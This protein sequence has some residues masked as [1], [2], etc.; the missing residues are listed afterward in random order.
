MD[1]KTLGICV[2]GGLGNQLFQIF[3]GLSKAI[4]ENKDLII[5]LINDKRI[6]HN[7]IIFKNLKNVLHYDNIINKSEIYVDDNRNYT[8]IPDNV[9]IICGF[10]Q[11]YKYFYDNY[12]KIIDILEIRDLQKKYILPFKKTIAIHLRMGDYL[13]YGC[14]ICSPKYYLNAINELKIKIHDINEYTFIIFTE[15]CNDSIINNQYLEIMNLSFKVVKI[16]DIMPNITDEEE[17]IYMSNCDH[18][19]IPNSTFSWWAAYLSKNNENKLVLYSDIWCKTDTISNNNLYH[20]DLFL[21][22]WIKISN[23]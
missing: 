13:E 1:Q 19:I 4:D 2:M 14:H 17:F 16:Y 9:N 3:T 5:Y 15:K 22:D 23:F 7:K 12:D 18:F 10:Y 8:K 11:S 21:K 20:D 6:Y